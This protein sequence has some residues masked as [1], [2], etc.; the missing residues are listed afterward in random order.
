ML[1]RNCIAWRECHENL[2]TR[3]LPHT[4]LSNQNLSTTTEQNRIKGG[5][6]KKFELINLSE[7]FIKSCHRYLS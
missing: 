4:A 1:S 2:L 3:R 6:K 5:R 7:M